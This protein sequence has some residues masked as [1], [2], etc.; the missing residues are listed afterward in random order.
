MASSRRGRKGT[1]LALGDGL[2][3]YVPLLHAK[4]RLLGRGS[5]RHKRPDRIQ[6]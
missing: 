3:L 5:V 2:L 4:G 6:R 1:C